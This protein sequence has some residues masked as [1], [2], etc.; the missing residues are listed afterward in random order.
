[1]PAIDQASAANKRTLEI[2][3]GKG[4]TLAGA[5]KIYDAKDTLASLKGAKKPAKTS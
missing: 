5:A 3:M 1:M 4:E 2:V